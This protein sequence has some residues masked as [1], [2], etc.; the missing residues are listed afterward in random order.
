MHFRALQPTALLDVFKASY[1]EWG[2]ISAQSL[3]MFVKAQAL[4]SKET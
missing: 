3:A 4:E 2:S 1:W